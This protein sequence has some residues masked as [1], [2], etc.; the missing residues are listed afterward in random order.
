[1]LHRRQ[2]DINAALGINFL[3]L[4]DDMRWLSR[5][6]EDNLLVTFERGIGLPT[7]AFE[8]LLRTAI[9]F[10]AKLVTIDNAADT[11]GGNENDRSQVRQF[12]QLLVRLARAIGGAVVLLA[13]PSRAG[14][15][16]GDGASGNTD[17][18][19]AVRSRLYLDRPKPNDDQQADEL[20]R[21][22]SR[23]K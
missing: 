10:R 3:D 13:H 11:F 18:S 2:C 15:A 20:A 22:L 7:L 23:R 14:L 9:E 19:N 6:G 17:W 8:R 16:T 12:I 21:T 1:E 4:F 5:V